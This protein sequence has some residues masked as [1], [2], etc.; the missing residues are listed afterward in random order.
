[1]LPGLE[2]Q[3]SARGVAHLALACSAILHANGQLSRAITL[4]LL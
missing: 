2:L 4:I 1:M 3:R